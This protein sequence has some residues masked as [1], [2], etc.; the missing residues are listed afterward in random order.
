MAVLVPYWHMSHY[1]D[2]VVPILSQ[3]QL[4]LKPG[5]LIASIIFFFIDSQIEQVAGLG[6]H[7]QDSQLFARFA[8]ELLR[9]PNS[10]IAVFFK[11]GQ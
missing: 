3:L 2:Q 8:G 6:V 1:P 5:K 4:L 7:R 9:G 11:L 10:K